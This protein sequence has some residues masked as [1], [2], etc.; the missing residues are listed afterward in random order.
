MY[1][2]DTEELLTSLKELGI[3]VEFTPS[4]DQ[5]L[6]DLLNKKDNKTIGIAKGETIERAFATI[7]RRLVDDSKRSKEVTNIL[8]LDRLSD[9]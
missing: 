4:R 7:I 3:E 6:V 2:I 8:D 5:F 1:T 9:L